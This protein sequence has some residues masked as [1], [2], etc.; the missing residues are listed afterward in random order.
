MCLIGK[1]VIRFGD[2]RE[3]RGG[4]KRVVIRRIKR[5]LCNEVAECIGS[6][7]DACNGGDGECAVLWFVALLVRYRP[8][9]YC[10]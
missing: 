3:N 9:R 5:R 6:N 10:I 1:E 2:E 4:Q 8:R 7:V